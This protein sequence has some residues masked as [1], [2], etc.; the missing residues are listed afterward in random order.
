MAPLGALNVAQQ[1]ADKVEEGLIC[2]AFVW[3]I[4]I[5]QHTVPYSR[6]VV[7][8]SGSGLAVSIGWL[9]RLSSKRILQ[10]PPELSGGRW[11]GAPS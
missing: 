6:F 4:G 5:S 9:T 1:H 7:G 2:R 3:L 10:H 11:V 8:N